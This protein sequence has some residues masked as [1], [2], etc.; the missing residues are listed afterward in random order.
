MRAAIYQ[1]N[2]GIDPLLGARALVEAA[3]RAAGAGADMLF[4]PEMSAVLDRDRARAASSIV[5]EAEDVA[6]AAM[7][8]TAAKYGLW[9]HL[10]S[11]AVRDKAG[12]D[13]YANRGYVID[14]TGA[15]DG[16]RMVFSTHETTNAIT[17]KNPAGTGIT[18]IRDGGG[19]T[20]SQATLMRLSGVWT[21]INLV[22]S[23]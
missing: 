16:D 21:A 6:L 14:D 18:Q 3:E 17:I 8:E 9:V 23:G 13:H 2:T 10:G 4:T 11:L 22:P 7:R 1:A 15:I 12:D 5:A 19:G 20:A